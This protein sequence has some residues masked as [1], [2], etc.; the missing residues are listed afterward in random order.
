MRKLWL[1]CALACSEPAL[2]ARAEARAASVTEAPP[3]STF[4]IEAYK[5]QPPIACAA[6]D[7][8][9]A[10]ASEPAPSD[11]GGPSDGGEDGGTAAAVLAAVRAYVQP[12]FEEHAA[13]EPNGH[14]R[15][16]EQVFIAP[17]GEV[18]GARTTLRVGLSSEVAS[19]VEKLLRGA[20]FEGVPSPLWVPLTWTLVHEGRVAG[21]P[22]RVPNV[23]T[24]GRDVT[25]LTEATLTYAT[26]DAGAVGDLAVD[27]WKG[28]Q[29][30]LA[31][32]AEAVRRAPHGASSQFVL[33]LRYHP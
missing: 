33:H 6:S 24:C 16:V 26:D 14:G 11:G 10:D 15:L 2:P 32:A 29:A 17:S 22:S 28:D 27:P 4:E 9:E 12:C 20:R 30:A 3:A 5:E 21:H 18:C 8:G 23:H 7:A 1:L 19:C 25:T 13:R 31:C